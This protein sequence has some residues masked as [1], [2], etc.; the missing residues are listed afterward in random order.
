MSGH[1]GSCSSSL[2]TSAFAA[3]GAALL[4]VA[5]ADSCSIGDALI[6]ALSQFLLRGHVLSCGNPHHRCTA[7]MAIATRQEGRRD[8]TRYHATTR[9]ASTLFHGFAVRSQRRRD[10]IDDWSNGTQ[11][12]PDCLEVIVS[13]AADVLPRHRRLNVA[14]G[15][16][17]LP[18]P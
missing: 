9:S 2:I 12:G 18:G 6:S 5:I 13:K 15:A 3:C 11:V 8:T 17:V 14:C 16:H 4:P 7:Q 10:V 1:G